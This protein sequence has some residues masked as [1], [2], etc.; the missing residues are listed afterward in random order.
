MQLDY[1]LISGLEEWVGGTYRI[2]NDFYRLIIHTENA[3]KAFWHIFK[4]IVPLNSVIKLTRSEIFGIKSE[5]WTENGHKLCGV[6][7]S[8]R[9]KSFGPNTP[10]GVEDAEVDEEEL[11]YDYEWPDLLSLE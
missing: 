6:Y 2:T 4:K 10:Y 9:V 3:Q 1:D 8:Y 11:K 7:G 5:L